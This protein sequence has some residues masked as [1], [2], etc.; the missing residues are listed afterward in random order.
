VDVL[1]ALQL[2]AQ[3]MDTRRIKETFGDRVA[4]FGGI[5]IQEVVPF[6]TTEKLEREVRRVIREAGPGGGY[7]L[8]GAHNI[9][10][11]TSVE[12][13]VKLFEFAKWHGRY[14]LG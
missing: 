14:P 1:N 9:Q 8:A 5:D 2:A 13:V 10:P 3:D 12:K 11:D 7:V 6:G 4:L